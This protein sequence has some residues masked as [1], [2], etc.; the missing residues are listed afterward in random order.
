MFQ[1]C[2][3]AEGKTAGR[4]ALPG[5]HRGRREKNDAASTRA[6]PAPTEEELAIAAREQLELAVRDI[7][8][9]EAREKAAADR[10]KA[11]AAQLKEKMAAD[12]KEISEKTY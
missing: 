5:D 4:E 9:E 2:T 3:I 11:R 8:M 12:R 10:M 1:C 7:V 6:Y